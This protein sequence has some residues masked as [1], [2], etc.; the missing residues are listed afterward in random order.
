MALAFALQG[1]A[2]DEERAVGHAT[3]ASHA[4]LVEAS[5][6]R[7]VARAVLVI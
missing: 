2:E 6:L 3:A 5:R 4:L 7:Q 1:E